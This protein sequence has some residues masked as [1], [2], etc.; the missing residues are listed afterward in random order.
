MFDRGL[1]RSWER[2]LEGESRMQASWGMDANE[3]REGRKQRGLTALPW[4]EKALKETV[5]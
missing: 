2:N 4:R 3:Q 5:V 1:L